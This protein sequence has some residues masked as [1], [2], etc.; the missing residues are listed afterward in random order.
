M[1]GQGRRMAS[2]RPGASC[3]QAQRADEARDPGSARVRTEHL[4]PNRI[5]FRSPRLSRGPQYISRLGDLRLMIGASL[6]G[7]TSCVAAMSGNIARHAG[8]RS[9]DASPSQCFPPFQSRGPGQSLSHMR[10]EL[11][12]CSGCYAGGSQRSVASAISRIL[13]RGNVALHV[14][15][16]TARK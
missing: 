16:T 2:S 1:P 7:A 5:Q 10:A 12:R 3:P 14:Q 11:S 13:S 15:R 4:N 9:P 6:Q 8:I